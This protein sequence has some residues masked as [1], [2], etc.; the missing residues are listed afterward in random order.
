MLFSVVL[1]LITFLLYVKYKQSYWN[2]R[3]LYQ[4]KPE[5]FFGNSR[6][7][8][9][10]RRS[11]FLLFRDG[12]EKA[13]VLKEK[14]YGI[15]FFWEPV[16]VPTDPGI[17]KHIM[18]KDFRHFHGHGW[19][20][21]PNDRLSRNLFSLE[22]DPWRLLRTKLTPTF[23]SGK[24][25]MMFDTL[26]AKTEGLERCIDEHVARQQPVDIKDC[27]A[28]F[29][30]DVI[31][32]SAFGIE[33]DALTNDEN[34]FRRYGKTMFRRSILYMLLFNTVP[35]WILGPMGFKFAPTDLD[36][37]FSQTVLDTIQYREKNNVSRKDFMHLL[38]Q[39]KNGN[40]GTESSAKSSKTLTDDEIIAQ[41][42][43]F[44]VAGFE[45]SSTTITFALLELAGNRDIQARLRKE[46]VEGLE[47]NDGVITYEA[48]MGMK[49]L[50]MVV[51]GK[52][53]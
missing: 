44:F 46:I 40:A 28:R 3:G 6:Q 43:G 7:E 32:S 23:T 50:D 20:S 25:K 41:C 52:C 39:L 15:Y 16:Y 38:L 26:M 11:L 19:F 8:L 53:P 17:I 10:G 12:Y 47:Q 22:G 42:F 34:E 49:Y 51:N 29:A 13:K 30:T 33:T 31:T 36:R 4:F 2:R 45:T 9:L 48:M 1:V 18:I 14:H 24:M 37:F 27:A 21:H 5:Y 35:S